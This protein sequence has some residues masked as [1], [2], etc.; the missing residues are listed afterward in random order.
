MGVGG[1]MPFCPPSS[2][3]CQTYPQV[4]NTLQ[5]FKS[6]PQ[7]IPRAKKLDKLLKICYMQ[8]EKLVKICKNSGKRIVKFKIFVK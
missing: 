2:Q 4:I 3:T 6:Y 5:N 1:G 8:L 7:V